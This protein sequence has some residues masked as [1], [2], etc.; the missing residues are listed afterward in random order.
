[1]AHLLETVVAY[2]VLHVHLDLHVY[3]LV[4]P[5]TASLPERN[6]PWVSSPG[7]RERCTT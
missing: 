5:V 4:A 7:Y 1:M 3:L 2:E 6:L